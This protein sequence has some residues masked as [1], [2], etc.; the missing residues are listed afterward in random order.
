MEKF[1]PAALGLFFSLLLSLPA[2]AYVRTMA[3]AGFPLYWSGA[4]IPLYLNPTNSSGLSSGQINTMISGAFQSWV[5]T[6]AHVS[7][8]VNSSNGNT[9]STGQDFTSRVY[10]S[11]NS[12]AKLDWGVIA[13][14]QVFYYT[15]SGQIVEAD[16]AFNDDNFHFT[17]NPGDTGTGSNI[18]LQDVATHEAG[19]AYG[20]DHSTVNRSTLVYRAFSGQYTLGED[21]QTAINTIYSGNNSG[22][23]TGTVRG[24]QGGMFGVHVLA[25][26]SSTGKVQA[27]TLAEPNGSFRIGNL[28]SGN[29]VVEMEPFYPSTSTISYYYTNVDHRFCGGSK[30][31]R[32][33]YGSCGNAGA[34]TLVSVGAGDTNIATLA[35]SCSAMG[36][37]AGNPAS[38]ASAR[39]INTSGGAYYGT[40]SN[41][42][43]HYYK[44]SNFSGD[45]NVR[46]MSYSLFSPLDPKVEI[47]SSTGAAIAGATSAD[48][49]ENPMPG[50]KINYDSLATA[51]GLPSADYIIKVTG[52][53]FS[54]G[55]NNFPAGSEYVDA[56]GFYLLLVGANGSYGTPSITDMSSCLSV[57]NAVQAANSSGPP[58][59]KQSTPTKEGGCGSLSLPSDGGDGGGG[60]PPL[61]S[62]SIFMILVTAFASRLFAS[63]AGGRRKS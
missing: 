48:N 9:P 36:N 3:N 25:I 21:D 14:T 29:Y 28:P 22:G 6:G 55:G 61:Y 11:S 24:T 7:F 45:L 39:S 34:A 17:A 43:V 42:A 26:N 33:F 4:N 59:S 60:G 56:R 40:L 57:N 23:I 30:F 18:Y 1:L 27:G 53:A 32:S 15:N 13:L 2:Q 19:H 35:P 10:F 8:N 54:I 20:L 5:N 16:L 47:L 50:G 37:P 52:G 58:P 63:L 31:A 38:I 44:I 46:A 49:V 62:T 12:S 51:T 41:S